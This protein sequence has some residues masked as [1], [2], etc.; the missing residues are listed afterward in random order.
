MSVVLTIT[1]VVLV[2]ELIPSNYYMLLP[3]EARPVSPMLSVAGYPP[4]RGRGTLYMTDVSVYKVDHKLE[5]LYGRVNTNADLEPTQAVSGNLSD[6]QYQRYNSRLMTNSIEEAQIAALT[7]VHRFKLSCQDT[8]PQV[9][10]TLPHTPAARVLVLGDLIVKVNGHTVCSSK[11]VFPL[12]RQVPPGGKVRVTVLRNGKT[13]SLALQTLA[14]TRTSHGL[15]PNRHGHVSMIGISMQDT[16]LP[17]EVHLPVK[18]R[19]N[20]GNTIGPSAGLMYTLG[21]VERLQRRD[22]A[23]GCKVAGTGTIDFAGNVG[24]IGGVKQKILA[25]RSAG[26]QYFLVPASPDNV[27]PARAY[28]GNITIIPVSTARE[29]LR[30][31]DR[32][33]PCR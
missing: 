28:R 9:E 33:T 8:K 17:R 12:V 5:E 30:A 23:R 7:L 11:Q 24:P 15:Q 21:I 4:I 26:V 32:L 10:F 3:G 2:L 25:A 14:A 6:R 31:L 22:L 1:L 16:L 13:V 20:P 27:G 18:I 29:A 19:I